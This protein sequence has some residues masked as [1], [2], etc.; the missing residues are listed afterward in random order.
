MRF[1][2]WLRHVSY[3]RLGVLTAV[4][5]LESHFI[6]LRHVSYI[7]LGALVATLPDAQWYLGFSA[8]TGWYGVHVLWL[9]DM[10]SLSRRIFLNR[11][12]PTIVYADLSQAHTTCSM[13]SKQAGG[14]HTESGICHGN[15]DSCGNENWKSQKNIFSVNILFFLWK[16][17]WWICEYKLKV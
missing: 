14:L 6:W 5:G 11:A 17:R 7:R 13:G 2:I 16:L 1:R 15:E 4:C 10:V 9:V 12:A 3:I 8:K